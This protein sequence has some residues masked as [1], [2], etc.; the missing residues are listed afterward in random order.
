MNATNSKGMTKSALARAM[1]ARGERDNKII[2]EVTGLTV[3]GVWHA[4]R[5]IPRDTATTPDKPTF[6]EH[7]T[8]MRLA[9]MR[10]D[11]CDRANEIAKELAATRV[12]AQRGRGA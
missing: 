1:Y 8:A 4:L 7:E 11:A 10:G 9:T 12:A 2:A 5:A 3:A 6:A